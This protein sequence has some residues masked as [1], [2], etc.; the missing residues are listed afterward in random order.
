MLFLSLNIYKG[1]PKSMTKV[2]IAGVTGFVGQEVLLQCLAHPSITSIVALCHH[3]LPTTHPKLHV[4]G[5]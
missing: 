3:E 1:H 4:H 5:T 2:I